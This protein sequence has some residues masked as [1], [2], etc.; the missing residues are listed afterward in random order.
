[1]SFIEDFTAAGSAASTIVLTIP[2]GGVAVGHTLVVGFVGLTSTGSGPT[3]YSATDTKGNTYT[4]AV[5][6]NVASISMGTCLLRTVVTA[7]L[8]SGD[9]ITVSG[10]TTLTRLAAVAAHFTD[11][12]YDAV[13]TSTGNNGAVATASPAA[14][15]FTP[16][17]ASTLVVTGF[18]FVSSGRVL[19]AG[20]G[21]TAG[22][23][24]ISNGGSGERAVQLEH[25]YVNPAASITP[26]ATLSASGVMDV[27]AGAFDLAPSAPGSGDVKVWNGTT[28]IDGTSKVWNGTAWIAGTRKVWNGTAWA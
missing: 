9:T 24:A 15:A 2:A 17:A 14:P 25:R 26:G 21:W 12:I 4:T 6:E 23:K 11:T 5:S 22:T 3:S 19:T 10:G 16:G 28:W 7:A 8:V 13:G 1:M 27:V 18:G 20:S